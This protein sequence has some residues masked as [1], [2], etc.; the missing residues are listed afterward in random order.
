[1]SKQDGKTA[2]KNLEELTHLLAEEGIPSQEWNEFGSLEQEALFWLEYDHVQRA[3]YDQPNQAINPLEQCKTLRPTIQHWPDSYEPTLND[4]DR[5][6]DIADANLRSAILAGDAGPST[7]TPAGDSLENHL[8]RYT[9]EM[10]K[11]GEQA[12]RFLIITQILEERKQALEATLEFYNSLT[13]STMIQT[14]TFFTNTLRLYLSTAQT[15][16]EEKKDANQSLTRAEALL[17]HV[18]LILPSKEWSVYRDLYQHL[19]DL[20]NG[21]SS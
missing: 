13:E 18:K 14:Q 12:D 8:T 15:Q 9:E 7:K 11:L 20:H 5:L 6:Q 3:L 10:D 21:K 16:I 1:L 2:R 19:I 4:L 17:E